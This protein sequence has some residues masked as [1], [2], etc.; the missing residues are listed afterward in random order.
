L[1]RKTVEGVAEDLHGRLG[2]RKVR[3]VGDRGVLSAA[4]REAIR[5]SKTDYLIA[6]GLRQAADSKEV[7]ARCEESLKKGREEDCAVVF[8]AGM[9][10]ERPEGGGTFRRLLAVGCGLSA[11]SFARENSPAVSPD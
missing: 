3:F 11:R 7:L 10:G 9:L 5:E 1:D 6:R 8:A 4:N 2:L